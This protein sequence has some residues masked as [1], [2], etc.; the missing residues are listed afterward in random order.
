MIFFISGCNGK[1]A[2]EFFKN[3]S[4]RGKL[5]IGLSYGKN[6]LS[7]NSDELFQLKRKK[8]VCNYF[9]EKNLNKIMDTLTAKELVFYHFGWGGMSEP[10]NEN[11]QNKNFRNTNRLIKILKK[12]SKDFQIKFFFA[13]SIEE[14]KDNE[15]FLTEKK[16]IHHKHK[17][18]YEYY[19][20]LILKENYNCKIKNFIYVHLVISNIITKKNNQKSLIGAI[21]NSVIKNECI[22]VKNFSSYR[23]FILVDDLIK[24]MYRLALKIN[25]NEIINLGNEKSYSMKFFYNKLHKE[26]KRNFYKNDSKIYFTNK[27]DEDRF[28]KKFN[29]DVSKVMIYTSI[30]LSFNYKYILEK[31]INHEK[32]HTNNWS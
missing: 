22:H 18:P 30:K 23:S 12:K 19:K 8:I 5:V 4:N 15:F 26:F 21:F 24:V 29:L 17:R 25:N 13:G 14:Y 16:L 28:K 11:L 32:K 3:L 7:E 1:I 20:N 9:K 2:S 27:N 10:S 6:N 31:I